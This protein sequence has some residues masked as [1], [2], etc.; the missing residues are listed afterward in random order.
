MK[1]MKKK[2]NLLDKIKTI[3]NNMMNKYNNIP[4]KTK[5]ILNLWFVILLIIVLIIIICSINN[6]GMEKYLKLED[7]ME[8]A[9][10]KYA[11]DKELAGTNSQKIRLDFNALIDERYLKVDKN[12]EKKC[13]GYALIY[14]N[15]DNEE[16]AS[17]YISCNGYTTDGFSSK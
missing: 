15:N 9:A 11:Q 7:E 1:K 4:K 16:K 6:N 3:I 17:A 2:N 8:K 12:L 5:K 10:L 14:T 13:I